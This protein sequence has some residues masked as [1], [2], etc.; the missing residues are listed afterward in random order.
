MP[1]RSIRRI[2]PQS[3]SRRLQPFEG[4]GPAGSSGLSA[5]FP[6]R[7]AIVDRFVSAKGVYLGASFVGPEGMVGLRLWM[8]AT[9]QQSDWH[10]VSPTEGWVVPVAA[11]HDEVDEMGPVIL[12][13]AV[14][15]LDELRQDIACQRLHSLTE[16]TA[17]CLLEIAERAGRPDLRLTHQDVAD[18]LGA[19]RPRV[20][21]ALDVLAAAGGIERGRGTLRIRDWLTV[22]S[23]SCECYSTVRS[24]FAAAGIARARA[25]TVVERTQTRSEWAASTIARTTRTAAAVGRLIEGS[26]RGRRR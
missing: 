13:L 17:R 21:A 20:T 15:T 9:P 16:R 7:G 6:R 3:Y 12:R 18:F 2:L 23:A 1:D 24:A 22:A 4:L 10:A 14:A 26:Q 11:L 19:S 8:G 5:F 25:L